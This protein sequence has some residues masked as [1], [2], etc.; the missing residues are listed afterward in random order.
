MFNKDQIETLAIAHVN[1][2][3]ARVLAAR[4]GVPGYNFNECRQYLAI[5]RTILDKGCDW[6]LLTPAERS[7]V[8]DAYED[9]GDSQGCG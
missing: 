4:E 3:E 9:E 6:E 8:R 2:Y 7:E 5:W 1:R